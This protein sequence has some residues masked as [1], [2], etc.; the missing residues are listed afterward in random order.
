MIFFKGASICTRKADLCELSTDC[1]VWST[2]S[3]L[4]PSVWLLL[5]FIGPRN[6]STDCWK[7]Q[8][9]ETG[10]LEEVVSELPGFLTV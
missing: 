8:Y 4:R 10:F 1:V 3:W 6:F 5:S 7:A 9:A 2:G